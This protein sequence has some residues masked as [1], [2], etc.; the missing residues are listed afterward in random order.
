MLGASHGENS[1][2]AVSR[3]KT[4]IIEN[5]EMSECLDPVELGKEI[6]AS[7][8]IMHQKHLQ[9]SWVVRNCAKAFLGR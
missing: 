6:F 9:H 5:T 2:I 7:S 8:A 4:F 1:A 3:A